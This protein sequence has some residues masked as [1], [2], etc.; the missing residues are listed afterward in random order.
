VSWRRSVRRV[1]LRV[2]GS[3][4]QVLPEARPRAVALH[5]DHLPAN[6]DAAVIVGD[7]HDWT[8][9]GSHERVTPSTTTAT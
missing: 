4:A 2:T 9:T 7:G 1:R 3:L 6:A 8:L 5:V